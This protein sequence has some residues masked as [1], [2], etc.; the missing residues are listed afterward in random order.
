MPPGLVTVCSCP[1]PSFCLVN[2]CL[3]S[4]RWP[5]MMDPLVRSS[6][7]Q[8]LKNLTKAGTVYAHRLQPPRK[9]LISRRPGGPGVSAILLSWGEILPCP[10]THQ[11]TMSGDIFGFYSYASNQPHNTKGS[12]NCPAQWTLCANLHTSLD[13]GC[14]PS[15]WLRSQPRSH[16]ARDPIS[17]TPALP[18]EVHDG[19]HSTPLDLWPFCLTA[20]LMYLDS[21]SNVFSSLQ[22]QFPSRFC[23]QFHKVLLSLH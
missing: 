3:S 4:P 6:W 10:L 21:T 15:S 9:I 8:G 13:C 7:T 14:S 11:E 2:L 17:S 16:L 1:H 23:A 12:Q 22:T 5:P 18:S 19:S 20:H